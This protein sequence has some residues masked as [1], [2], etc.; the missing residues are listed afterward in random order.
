VERG[1]DRP[2][3]LPG[4]FVREVWLLGERIQP[5]RPPPADWMDCCWLALRCPFEEQRACKKEF[6]ASR[7]SEAGVRVLYKVNLLYQ[8]CPARFG[9]FW[10]AGLAS[11]LQIRLLRPFSLL[12]ARRRAGKPREPKRKAAGGAR[13]LISGTEHQVKAQDQQR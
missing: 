10:L 9:D 12:R 1:Q 6:K 7:A 5:P 4:T 8:F 13:E 2:L 3:P 11:P